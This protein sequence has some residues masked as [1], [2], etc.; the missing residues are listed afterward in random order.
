MKQ[1]EPYPVENMIDDLKEIIGEMEK[2]TFEGC[3]VYSSYNKEKAWAK[4]VRGNAQDRLVLVDAALMSMQYDP[5]EESRNWFFGQIYERFK[6]L[7]PASLRE[8]DRAIV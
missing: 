3:L 1:V 6:T 7:R 5:V 2:D 4:M 8:A